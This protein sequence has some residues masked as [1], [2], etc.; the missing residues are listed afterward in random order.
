MM[1]QTWEQHTSELRHRFLLCLTSWFLIFILCYGF[2]TQFL[3]FILPDAFIIQTE[4]FGLVYVKMFSSFFLSLLLGYPIFSWH[5]QRFVFPDKKF[6]FYFFPVFLFLSG[7][8]LGIYLVPNIL[9]NL[10]DGGLAYPMYDIYSI[11]VFTFGV[12]LCFGIIF[13][14]PYFV[15]TLRISKTLLRR[16]RRHV[17]F[18]VLVVSGVLTPDPTVLSQLLFTLVFVCVYEFSIWF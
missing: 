4:V 10:S 17:L 8:I 18:F 1:Y 7:F 6:K 5:I 9:F 15:K 2:S 12:G 11:F 13:L 16:Y 14:W 3:G